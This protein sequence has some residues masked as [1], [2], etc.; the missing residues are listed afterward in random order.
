LAKEK[1]DISAASRMPQGR[2]FNDLYLFAQVVIH[3]GYSSAS[4]TLGIPKSRLSRRVAALEDRLGSRLVQRSS[5]TFAI[6]AAGQVFL[7]HCLA[8]IADAEAAELAV[9]QT[10]AR[11]RGLV[12]VSCTIS[13][14]QSM[15]GPILPHFLSQ[16]PEVNVSLV[17][18][19]RAV[20]LVEEGFDVALFIHRTPLQ[21]SSLIVRAIGTSPQVLVASPKLFESVPRPRSPD[22]LRSVPTLSMNYGLATDDWSLGR[23]A[24]SYTAIIAEPRL[25]AEN[26]LILKDAAL[27]AAGVARLPKIICGAELSDGSLEVV[28][29]D[30]SMPPH[31]IHACYPSRKGLPPAVRAFV[32]FVV[33]AIGDRLARI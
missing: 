9:A 32:E 3:N 8:M 28:L 33:K 6:T 23:G 27:G 22:D 18:T 21:D 11:P 24:E 4:R 12:R 16:N 30:W 2:D 14:A 7:R 17:S 1:L 31:E 15:L 13:M 20:N 19:N 25:I 26:L 5:R 10:Q 29:P